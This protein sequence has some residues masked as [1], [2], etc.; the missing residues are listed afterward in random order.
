[1]VRKWDW[2]IL[3]EMTHFEAAA[4]VGG[5][6]DSNPQ[7]GCHLTYTRAK[8]WLSH[9]DQRFNVHGS[10]NREQARTFFTLTE[11]H[12]LRATGFGASATQ[13]SSGRENRKRPR[14]PREH[15]G[16]TPTA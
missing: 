16:G 14:P 10:A 9:P 2:T 3:G 5:D 15:L 6:R 13:L 12:A 11:L 7:K 4:R 1:M 8:V